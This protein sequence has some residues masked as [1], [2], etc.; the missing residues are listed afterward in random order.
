V[1]YTLPE[2]KGRNHRLFVDERTQSSPAYKQFWTSLRSGACQT[3]ECKRIAKSG[4]EVWI[5]ASYNPILRNGKTVRIVKYASVI[6]G[7]TRK[8]IDESGQ[9]AAINRSQAVIHFDLNGTIL[10]ANDNFLKVMGYQSA[11]ITGRHHSIF[12]T[13]EER[14]S[15]AYTAFWQRLRAGHFEAAEYCRQAKGG[16]QVWLQATYN[17]ILDPDG[18]PVKIVKFATDITAMVQKRMRREQ[19]GITLEKNLDSVARAVATTSAQAANAA[20]ASTQTAANVQAVAAGAEKFAASIAEISRRMAEASKTTQ[21]AIQQA[22]TTNAAVAVLLEATAE[23]EQVAQLITSIA[24]QTNLLA[25]N[26]TIEAA[27][28]GDAGKGFAV[29]ASEVKGLAGQTALATEDISK[30]IAGI[31]AASHQAVD[32]IRQISQ[33]V[34]AINTIATAIAAAVEEQDSVAREMSANMETAAQGV[35]EIDSSASL[36]AKAT[37]HAEASVH[38]V[39]DATRQ[40][41]A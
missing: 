17:P 33:T 6:T 10:W 24:A 30:H 35:A 20:S 22:G 15:A 1:G 38:E 13:S 14:D 21:T 12:V 4:E 37:E 18:K 23:I 2:I 7:R 27:R 29:V 3:A 8:A 32:A 34:T 16:H 28:A 31:Q 36:I 41:I 5:Q 39:R 40:L 19:I 9:V 26:A 11:E 25:L